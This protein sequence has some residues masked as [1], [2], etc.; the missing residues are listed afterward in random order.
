MKLLKKSE[1]VKSQADEKKIE[2]DEGMALARSIENLREIRLKEEQSLME[3]RKTTRLQIQEE[4]DT[5]LSEK[6]GILDQI[7]DNQ[8][9]REE[10]LK[11]L[12][13]EWE[14]VHLEKQKIITEKE[15]LSKGNKELE[16]QHALVKQSMD[17]ISQTLKLTKDKETKAKNL[18]K[19]SI[20]LKENAENEY[21]LK[22]SEHDIQTQEYGL[23]LEELE[24]LKASYQNG[25]NVNEMDEKNLNEREQELIIREQALARG[26]NALRIAQEIIK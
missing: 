17:K 5:A 26:Q 3:Y 8:K 20:A 4:I 9:I 14:E 22:K 23:R 13:K 7:K 10:L 15:L 16:K 24:L 25:I 12:N 18:L 1:I 6:N 11:P 2:I 19:E 21:L